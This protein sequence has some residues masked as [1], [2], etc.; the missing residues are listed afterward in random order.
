MLPQRPPR[1]LL[2]KYNT[3]SAPRRARANAWDAFLSPLGPPRPLLWSSRPFSR[4]LLGP[5]LTL[6]PLFVLNLS[7]RG[8]L[9]MQ[10]SLKVQTCF[11]AQS[12]FR[13]GPHGLN[14]RGPKTLFWNTTGSGPSRGPWPPQMLPK[15][16]PRSPADNQAPSNWGVAKVSGTPKSPK[17]SARDP[18]KSSPEYLKPGQ[19][20]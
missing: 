10:K 3:Y 9:R 2:Y 14:L 1:S 11:V 4:D 19:K 13:P 12:A 5:F 16:S 20:H 6:R 17:S 8:P 18:P 7:A 15:D